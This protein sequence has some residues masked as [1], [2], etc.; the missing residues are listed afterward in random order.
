MVHFHV[1][2]HKTGE[3][4][5]LQDTLIPWPTLTCH[6]LYMVLLLGCLYE[7]IPPPHTPW[8]DTHNTLV[9]QEII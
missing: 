6:N 9:K 3:C 4:Y 1:R 8:Y 7:N 5:I 2:L